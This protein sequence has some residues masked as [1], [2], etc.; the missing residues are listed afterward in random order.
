MKIKKA[1]GRMQRQT[2]VD[3]TAT[4]GAQAIRRAIEVIRLVAQIQRSG[5]TL[6][7]VAGGVR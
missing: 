4:G 5:A 2:R 7:R 6:S 3:R 1:T